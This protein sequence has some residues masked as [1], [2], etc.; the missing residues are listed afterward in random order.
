MIAALLALALAAPVMLDRVDVLS[1]DPG[2]LLDGELAKFRTTA[3]VARIRFAEQIKP[4]LALPGDRVYVGLSL[5]SQSVVLEQPVWGQVGLSAGV[6]AR[7]LLPRGGLVGVY[8]R[9]GRLRLGA[10]LNLLSGA[11]W[12]RPDYTTWR[13]LPGVGLGIGRRASCASHGSWP[14]V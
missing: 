7:A 11:T 1:E 6:Q 9:H 4:V 8:G 3:S 2:A 5:G 10:S 13:V 12:A 14:R